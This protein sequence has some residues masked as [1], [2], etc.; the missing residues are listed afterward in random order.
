MLGAEVALRLIFDAPPAVTEL[1]AADSGYSDH[2]P[3]GS[4][5]IRGTESGYAKQDGR[6]RTL[7]LG[8]L[9]VTGHAMNSDK[10]FSEVMKS[11][12]NRGQDE[13]YEVIK[14]GTGG[15]STSQELR[16]FVHEGR[17]YKPDLTVLMFTD[18]DIRQNEKI[19]HGYKPRFQ[20]A[21]G[22][23]MSAVNSLPPAAGADSPG[24]SREKT[25][26][27]L[28]ALAEKRSYLYAMITNHS[29]DFLR[30]MAEI[31]ISSANA[32]SDHV[33]HEYKAYQKNPSQDAS[34]AWTSTERLIEQLKKETASAGSELVVFYVPGR[35][36]VYP[37]KWEKA[38]RV[39]G[40]SDAEWDITLVRDR[41][42]DI[43]VR[44]RIRFMD[45]LPSFRDEANTI[46]AKSKRLYFQKDDHW[47]AEGHDLA[48]NILAKYIEESILNIKRPQHL[49]LARN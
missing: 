41:I 44:N 40:M 19:R 12:M 32:K 17:K 46:Q 48:G 27:R 29:G 18:D 21:N 35:E 34:A 33:P 45:S 15:Y 1:N 6:Y 11:R 16:Y 7:I 3:T 42:R 8:D 37:E 23:A 24:R 22:T 26:S 49:M 5:W 31:F 20:P 4:K 30:K 14:T 38:K 36:V 10:V 13:K 9:S 28:G 43:C 25:V 2:L 47:T 39:H